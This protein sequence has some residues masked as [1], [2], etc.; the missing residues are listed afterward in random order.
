MRRSAI[1]RLGLA[2]GLVVVLAVVIGF[3]LSDGPP[4][5]VDSA[6]SAAPASATPTPAAPATPAPRALTDGIYLVG[7]EVPAGVYTT[8]VPA[9]KAYGCYWARL[10]SFGRSDSIIDQRN[11]EPG[12]TARVVV[13]PTDKGFKVSNGCTWH[14]AL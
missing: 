10:R 7:A 5:P 2:V 6:P 12:E 4:A 8:A 13:K 14:Q 9:T 3:A 1:R 11:L